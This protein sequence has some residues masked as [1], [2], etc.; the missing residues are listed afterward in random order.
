MDIRIERPDE[1]RDEITDDSYIYAPFATD[2]EPESDI[3]NDIRAVEETYDC[4]DAE[5]FSD[6]PVIDDEPYEEAEAENMDCGDEEE[7]TVPKLEYDALMERYQRLVSDWDNYRRRTAE[8][9]AQAKANANRN[10]AE[11]L[12]PT[13]DH[14][15]F[16]LAHASQMV[17]NPA[18]QEMSKGF[19]AIY[20]AMLDSLS[21]E[22]LS[23]IDPVPG[24]AFDMN[25]NQA[26]E[27]IPG[28][29][30]ESESVVRVVQVGYKFNDYVI[31]P[32]M[33]AVAS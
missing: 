7:E 14:F 25:E 13:F 12:I 11:A 3:D 9:I 33:V 10:M 27:Q 19:E 28:T 29:G 17:D 30:M 26:V 6:A 31:R 20:R 2:S 15:G 23:V 4:Y 8:D 5:G 21:R 1:S 32:A 24:S 16:A 22:G 18:A